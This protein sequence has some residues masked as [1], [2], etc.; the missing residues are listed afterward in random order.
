MHPFVHTP[1]KI[2]KYLIIIIACT[3]FCEPKN[4]EQKM[5]SCAN[6][7]TVRI[8]ESIFRFSVPICNKFRHNPTIVPYQKYPFYASG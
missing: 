8:A 3:I 1:K 7:E 5:K 4:Y 2:Q 6:M